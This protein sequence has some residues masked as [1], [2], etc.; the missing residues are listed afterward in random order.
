MRKPST[1]HRLTTPQRRSHRSMSAPSN[2]RGAQV[3]PFFHSPQRCSQLQRWVLQVFVP[4]LQ[5]KSAPIYDLL[6]VGLVT[7]RVASSFCLAECP[8]HVWLCCFHL[9]CLSP[10]SSPQNCAQVLPLPSPLR[11]CGSLHH[12]SRMV[13][14]QLAKLYR[15]V[16]F[17]HFVSLLCSC[18][19]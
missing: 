11:P 9:G 18:K 13:L 6:L 8:K 5:S 14:L 1:V 19:P 4:Q 7:I 15:V 12:P 2:R 3:L 16:V 10:C 17:A